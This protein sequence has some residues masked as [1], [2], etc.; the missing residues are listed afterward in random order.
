MDL[1]WNANQAA[2]REQYRTFGH[3]VVAPGI[4]ER[5]RA[6]EFHAAAWKDLAA[7]GFWLAHLRHT[8][9]GRGG[10]LWDFLAGLEGLAFGAEDSGFVLSTVAHAGLLHVLLEHGTAEQ[11]RRIVPALTAGALGATA[12]TEPGGGSHVAAVA[13]RTP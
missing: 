5:D 2:L 8:L 1:T 4:Y 13:G 7:S 11:Q 10:T 3:E 6:A 9:G 12:A